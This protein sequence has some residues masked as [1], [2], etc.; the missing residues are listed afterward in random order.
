MPDPTSPLITSLS[1]QTWQIRLSLLCSWYKTTIKSGQSKHLLRWCRTFYYAACLIVKSRLTMILEVFTARKRSWGKVMFSF[2]C[3]SVILFRGRGGSPYDNYPWC[4]GT[5][6]PPGYQTW[7]PSPLD[8]VLPLL[9]SA[10][11]RWRPVKLVDLWT[12]PCSIS[13]VQSPQVGGKHP[14]GKL[15]CSHEI[16]L[17]SQWWILKST[18]EAQKIKWPMPPNPLTPRPP[19]CQVHLK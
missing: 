11:H 4:I 14:T 12:T 1:Q 8:M 10:G 18:N 6:R 2:S 7:D 5:W 16:H 9:T 3:L 19:I 15:S 17:P 13:A